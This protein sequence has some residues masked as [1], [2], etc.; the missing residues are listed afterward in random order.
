MSSPREHHGTQTPDRYISY[1]SPPRGLH[2][3][4][5]VTDLFLTSSPRGLH[6][7]Q[8]VNDLFLMSSPR[9]LHGTQTC[10]RFISYELSEGASWDSDSWSIYFLRA[11]RESFMGPKLVTDL[12]LTS[13]LRGL[14]GTQT[15]D[16][17]ISYQ[18]S[19]VPSIGSSS[20][21]P[22]IEMSSS[23]DQRM[24]WFVS[25]DVS[26]SGHSHLC[27]LFLT[28]VTR[29]TQ[30]RDRFVSLGLFENGLLWDQK[31]L[32]D[33]LRTGSPRVVLCW[34][35]VSFWSHKFFISGPLFK[36]A[37]Q[38]YAVTCFSKSASCN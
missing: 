2:G 18:L 24:D 26:D 23:L 3:T 37:Q 5:T 30:T 10:D 4:Q 35:D 31:L 19:W 22:H 17:F 20:H 9:G 33:S 32:T 11:L 28:Y 8:T 34:R 27:F 1:H 14:K 36:I 12:F 7:T 15:H 25:H 21:K 38:N 6:G 16:Q 29:G 13:S